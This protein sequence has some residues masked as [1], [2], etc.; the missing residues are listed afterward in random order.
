M[1]KPV[2]LLPVPCLAGPGRAGPGRVGRG[3]GNS[4]LQGHILNIAGALALSGEVLAVFYLHLSGALCVSCAL[5][6]RIIIM[7]SS[8]RVWSPMYT[9]RMRS[10]L[11]L[12]W[13]PFL[14]QSDF[15][16]LRV[17][18]WGRERTFWGGWKLET[19]IVQ[20]CA[21]IWRSGRWWEACCDFVLFSED[22]GTRMMEELMVDDGAHR[23]ATDSLENF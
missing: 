19:E 5:R 21:V 16:T 11:V 3:G 9:L 23:L 17:S 7:M 15:S 10:Q 22:C 18:Q 1:G 12:C 13:S 2:P 14:S 20:L 8:S 4:N 6:R